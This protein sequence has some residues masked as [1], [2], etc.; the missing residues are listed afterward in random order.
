[1]QSHV[2]ALPEVRSG[3]HY[4]LDWLRIAAFGL[5]ILYHIGMVF[6]PWHWVIDT[7]RSYP[8]LIPPMAL[9]TPWRLSLLFAVSG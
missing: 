9:L 5:L 4:G 2:A 3:R 7:D 8:E 6:A 1:M